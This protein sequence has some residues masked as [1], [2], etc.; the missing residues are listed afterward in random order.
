[1]IAEI[2]TGVVLKRPM[3]VTAAMADALRLL[4]AHGPARRVRRGWCW[5]SFDGPFIAPSTMDALET[6]GHIVKR[7][8]GATAVLTASGREAHDDLA[9]TRS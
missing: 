6:R 5:N 1:M 3:K 8:V 2:T 7:H 9:E 4:V